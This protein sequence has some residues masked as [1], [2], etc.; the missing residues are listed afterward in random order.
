MYH[1]TNTSL[2]LTALFSGHRTA[3]KVKLDEQN[4]PIIQIK[5]SSPPPKY[6]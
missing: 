3:Q 1:L 6:T 2:R 4:V 5:D